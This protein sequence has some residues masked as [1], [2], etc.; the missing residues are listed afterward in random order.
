VQ[1]ANTHTTTYRPNSDLSGN[2]SVYI[3]RKNQVAQSV[4]DRQLVRNASRSA[5]TL[6]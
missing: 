1:D 4:A 2:P 3:D 5:L 6:Y